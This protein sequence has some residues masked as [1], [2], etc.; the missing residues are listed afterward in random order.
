MLAAVDV[1]VTSF[2]HD[3]AIPFIFLISSTIRSVLVFLY[4]YFLLYPSVRYLTVTTE[5]SFQALL[6]SF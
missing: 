5:T 3:H 2:L 6:F 4:Q 1:Q